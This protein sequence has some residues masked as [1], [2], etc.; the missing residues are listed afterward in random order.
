MTARTC[1]R[2]AVMV[3]WGR[4]AQRPC[5]NV[6]PSW[7]GVAGRLARHGL[8]AKCQSAPEIAPLFGTQI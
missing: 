3:A 5:S 6:V 8:P 7:G 4:A 2:E 1:F